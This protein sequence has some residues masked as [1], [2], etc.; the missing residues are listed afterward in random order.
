MVDFHRQQISAEVNLQ[1]L[2][3]YRTVLPRTENQSGGIWNNSGIDAMRV[4][5]FLRILHHVAHGLAVS[6]SREPVL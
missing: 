6:G 5:D 3:P 4:Q 2:H 1:N